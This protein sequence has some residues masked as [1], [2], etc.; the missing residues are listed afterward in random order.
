MTVSEKTVVGHIDMTPT[1]EALLPSILLVYE[2]H[3]NLN[4]RMWAKQELERMA[5]LADKYVASQKEARQ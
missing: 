1:W 4:T 5:M 2:T 3:P